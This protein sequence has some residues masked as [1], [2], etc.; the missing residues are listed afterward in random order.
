MIN[1]MHGQAWFISYKIQRELKIHEIKPPIVN[2]QH[3]IYRFQ[4]DLCDVGF[5]PRHLH[6]RAAEYTKQSSSVTKHFIN[7]HCIS[8]KDLY[9]DIFPFSKSTWVKFNCLA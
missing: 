2:Q 1:D 3:I 7:E 6:Q 8:S 5:I 9:W 4:C